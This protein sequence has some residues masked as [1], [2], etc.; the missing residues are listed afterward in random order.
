MSTLMAPSRVAARTTLTSQVLSEWPDRAANSSALALTDSGMPERDPGDAALLLVLRARRRGR[1]AAE[2]A[3][4]AARRGVDHE[5]ELAAVEAD[6]DATGRHLGGDLGGRLGDGLHQG[7]AGGRVEG[8]GEPLGGG[9]GLGA[10]RL[11]GREQVAPE[12]VDVR[13][14]VHVHHDDI[15]MT[16]CQGASDVTWRHVT[17][18]LPER[19]SRA[20]L[21]RSAA[22]HRVRWLRAASRK[23]PHV[24]SHGRARRHRHG[25]HHH[26]CQ[27]RSTT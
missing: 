19:V 21:C 8:E 3:G 5:R 25:R 1:G 6:V 11:G 9:V 22:G 17:S 23:G 24:A 20:R 14:D 4:W 7:Q 2:P 13:R 27:L 12:A 16:S 10:G 26:R 18:S 15:I